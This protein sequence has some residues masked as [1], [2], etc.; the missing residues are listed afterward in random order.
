VLL[1]LAVLLHRSRT[2]EPLPA[3]ALGLGAGELV[4][5]APAAWLDANP[6]TLADLHQEIEHL[7]AAGVRLALQRV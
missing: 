3:L 6:L 5:R 2:S 4:L 1:R 7:C